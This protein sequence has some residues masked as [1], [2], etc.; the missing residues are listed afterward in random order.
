MWSLSDCLPARMRIAKKSRFERSLG[1]G[2]ASFG[3]SRSGCGC[4]AGSLIVSCGSFPHLA[5]PNGSSDCYG[6]RR[7]YPANGRFARATSELV[8]VALALV[9]VAVVMT[10]VVVGVV[11]FALLARCVLLRLGRV[12]LV[13]L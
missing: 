9:A 3:S 4:G 5:R 2:S 13:L 1:V 12:L 11:V 6:P 8:A 7:R 10:A